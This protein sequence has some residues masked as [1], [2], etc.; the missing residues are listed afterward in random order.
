MN[1]R[2]SQKLLAQELCSLAHRCAAR[3][4]V[5]ATAGNFSFCESVEAD[6]DGR[7]FVSAS[8]L[9]KGAMTPEDLL[10][11]ALE[12]AAPGYRVVQAAAGLRPSAETSLHAVIYRDRPEARAIAHV[13]SIW[14]TLLSQ[15]HVQRW[16]RLGTV[17]LADYELLKALDGIATHEHSEQIPILE[18]SQDYPALAEKLTQVLVQLPAA[19]GVLLHGHGLYTWGKSIAEVWRHIEA[20]EFLFQVE[21][22]RQMAGWECREG[23]NGKSPSPR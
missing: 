2:S 8:G 10:E 12:T 9:D 23:T 6:A 4:W 15:R 5:P 13:H 21:A 11:I 18:N 1:D 20:L 19:H 17:V 22:R 3:G 16:P 14:N 7:I